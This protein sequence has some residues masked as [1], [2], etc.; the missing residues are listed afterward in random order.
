MLHSLALAKYN[1]F[2]DQMNVIDVGTGG[3]F[4]GIPLAIMFPKVN[5]TL[6]DATAKKIHV[7]N[8]VADALVLENV[9]GVHSRVEEHSGQFDLIIS[10]AVT[11]LDQ[12]IK[13]TQQLTTSNRWIFFKGGD[14]R[15]LRK[16]LPPLFNMSFISIKDYFNDEY[17]EEKWIVDVKR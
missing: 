9:T 13:W 3:G 17:F 14:Q 7:V 8:E 12:T 16:E 1:P 10:R 15:S 4:P 5:F 11:S 6:L 2:E